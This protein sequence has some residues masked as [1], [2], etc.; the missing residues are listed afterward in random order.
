MEEL[1]KTEERIMHVLWKLK[2]AFVKDI[3]QHLDEDPAPPYTTISSVVRILERKGYVSFKAYGKTYEYSPVI[4]KL[5]YRAASLKRML[6]Q[7]FDNS[8]SA[9]VSFMV[10]EE[11]LSPEEVQRLRQ[12]LDQA[13]PD[14][15]PTDDAH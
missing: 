2:R 1:T 3:I 8:P 15:A 4:S 14:T 10:E 13:S 6:T 9:L 7:Y 12:L 5:E 11:S